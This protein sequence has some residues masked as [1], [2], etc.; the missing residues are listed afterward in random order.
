MLFSIVWRAIKSLTWNIG[1]FAWHIYFTDNW[2]L[3]VDWVGQRGEL[4]KKIN[5]H[6]LILHLLLNFIYFLLFFFFFLF[7]YFF[8]GS[9]SHHK[10][11]IRS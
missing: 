7:F 8:L 11:E 9:V 3:G 2:I 10:C 1:L 5:F 6:D 4:H